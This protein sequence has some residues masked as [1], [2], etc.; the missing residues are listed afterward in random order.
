MSST[1]TIGVIATNF[2]SLYHTPLIQMVYNR[3]HNAGYQLLGVMGA[4]NEIGN[5]RV[6]FDRVDGW[7]AI[8]NPLGLETV[9][10]SGKPIVLVG[11]RHQSIPSITAD[12]HT[13][14][15]A[16]LMHLISQGRRRIAFITYGVNTDFRDRYAIF[17]ATLADQG[18]PPDEELVLDVHSYSV[19]D[20]YQSV[21]RMIAGGARFD[22]VFCANDWLAFG[23][24]QA[25]QEAGWH[26]PDDVAVT[27]FDD[28]TQAQFS[29]P[30]LTSVRQDP[31]ELG[32]IGLELLLNQIEHGVVPPA[33]TTVPTELIVRQS[34]LVT[35]IS[36]VDSLTPDRYQ[37]TDWQR[38]LARDLT[39]YVMSPLQLPADVPPA[40]FWPDV[41]TIVAALADT[42]GGGEAQEITPDIWER[43]PYFQRGGMIQPIIELLHA[44]GV[45]RVAEAD[46]AALERLMRWLL[47]CQ[48]HAT[49][50]QI[51]DSINQAEHDRQLFFRENSLLSSLG[52]T[53]A[54]PRRI[55][56]MSRS[57]AEWAMLGLWNH[58]ANAAQR[59]M[60]ITSV[61]TPD[62]GA[63]PNGA[64]VAPEDFP[65]CELLPTSLQHK[66]EW[67]IKITPLTTAGRN[68]GYLAYAEPFF[69]TF[70]DTITN[71]NSYIAAAL[72]REE[73]L[74][75]LQERQ[76]ILQQ[77]YDRERNLADTIRELG[78][79]I[80]PLLPGVL[81]VPLVGAIDEARAAEIIERVLQG[82]A[83]EQAAQVLLDITGVP[84]V[85]TQIAAAL[86]QTAQA[87]ALLGASVTL[88]GVRPEIAQSIV[89]LGIDLTKLRSRPTLAAAL[90]ELIRR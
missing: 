11:G 34:S 52:N 50:Q 87:V 64:L 84:L 15:T 25:I 4:P 72:E 51:S 19:H 5:A 44:A 27:G 90:Q 75:S 54:S 20:A 31:A 9:L 73:L 78:C 37:G 22:A 16:A 33:L 57:Q 55:D 28:T 79:P 12:N 17:C 69:W 59:V 10:A 3:L 86:I 56:W 80:I 6:A 53:G 13:G 63:T 24:I 2:D 65:P 62:T 74:G 89:G 58:N 18:I 60:E 1:R 67:M 77:A 35:K 45:Q 14:T 47:S 32:R 36:P 76:A 23:T 26:I 71:R 30:P 40:Q 66:P 68:W 39:Q 43:M 81:L 46:A 38:Q 21:R 83:D 85:D 49:Q 48:Q 42:I 88:V 7:L 29:T 70:S 82:V 8:N 61:Y 41:D